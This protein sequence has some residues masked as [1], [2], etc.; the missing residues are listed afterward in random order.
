[1]IDHIEVLQSGA[2]PLYGSDAIAGVVNVIT[3]AQQKGLRASAQFGTFRQ[4]D[5]HTQDY[6]LS[7]G[8]KLPTTS[9]VFGGSYVKQEA[10]RSADRDISQFPNP[11]QGSCTDP[12]RGCSSA[13]L[14][15]R[16]L[17]SFGSQTISTAPD[18]TPIFAERISESSGSV[19]P[20]PAIQPRSPFAWSVRAA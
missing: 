19:M 4:G 7:Y 13:A 6:N 18:S 8:L 12:V 20:P 1:M 3:V 2:S 17:T 15:G 11:G 14:N 5:G 10:V 9:I 16:F